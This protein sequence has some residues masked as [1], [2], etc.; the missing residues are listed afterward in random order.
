M[1]IPLLLLEDKDLMRTQEP[2][3]MKIL[4]LLLDYVT[5]MRTH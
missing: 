5:L 3:P 4:L 1:K 2:D